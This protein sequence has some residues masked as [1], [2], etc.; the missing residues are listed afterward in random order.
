MHEFEEAKLESLEIGPLPIVRLYLE[1]LGLEEMFGRHL[2]KPRRGRPAK[3]PAERVLSILVSNILVSHLPLYA[4]QQWAEGFV[5]ELL[6]LQPGQTRWLND[7]RIGRAIDRLFQADGMALFT[8][9]V[10]TAVRKFSIRLDQLH[11]DSTSVTFHGKYNNKAQPGGKRPPKITYGFNKDHRPDLK[12]LV[13]ELATTCDGN[14]PIYFKVHD[15]NMTDDQMHCDTWSALR[16]LVGS[17]EFLYVADCKLAVSETMRFIHQQQGTFLSVLP[18]TRKE[19]SQ[20]FDYI[21]S[22]SIDWQ[23][24]RREPNPAAAPSPSPILDHLLKRGDEP[25]KEEP[26]EF[27]YEAFESPHLSKEGFRIFWY[28]SSKKMRDDQERRGRRLAV[29]RMKIE[30]LE[31]SLRKTRPIE[32]GKA[33]A[34]AQAILH[35]QQVAE[36]MTVQV[37]ARNRSQYVQDGPGRPGPNT[38]YRKVEIPFHHFVLQEQPEA[39]QA[40]ARFDG[41]FPLI[42]NSRTLTAKDALDAYKQQPFLEKRHQQLKSVLDM[43]PVHLKSPSR[44]AGLLL[45]NYLALL[46][47]SLIERDVRKR[48]KKAKIASLPLYP[49]Q[50]VCRAPTTDLIFDAFAGLRRHRLL[51][52]DGRHLRTFYDAPTPVACELLTLLGVAPD[53]FG[54]T[55]Q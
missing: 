31:S 36:F 48:M 26:A 42:T 12:Q 16:D 7:D 55:R 41:L 5:P 40:A 37:E 54:Q 19:T 47:Y 34:Q 38:P 50:R 11:S 3:L 23:V 9:A 10:V 29:A 30:S 35:E 25:G 44:V 46:V 22:H 24:V 27:V 49:E 52:G 17:P 1:R 4:V 51:A 45:L 18:R 14:V 28:R 20:F 53:N 21:Q 13:A 15:G 32:A 8:D 39:I 2:P 33:L 43:A 6:G